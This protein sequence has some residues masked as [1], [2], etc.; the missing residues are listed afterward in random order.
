MKKLKHSKYKNTGILFEMLVH[1]LTSETMT[2]DKSISIDIIKKYFSKQSE[3]SKE[4]QLYNALVK[5]QF[6]S[7]SRALEYIRMIKESHSKLNK[8]VLRRQRYNLVKEIKE[9][10]QF[11]SLSKIR[12]KNYKTLA[13]AYMLFEY[14]ESD[15]P[16]TLMECKGVVLDHL[17]DAPQATTPVNSIMDSFSS[18]PK[19]VR[20]L[21]YEYVV[22]KFND[23]YSDL[24]PE[25]KSLLSKYI[26]HI[27]DSDSLKE[28]ISERVPEI[29]SRLAKQHKL[30]TDKSTAIKI[31]HLS[32]ML[33]NV[34]DVHIV[35]ESH[36]LTLLRYYNLLNELETVH[37][38]K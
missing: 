20:L 36:V 26:T 35:K 4:M 34:E 22:N 14:D 24:L 17:I 3:L 31:K 21:A 27:H 11:E 38:G 15:N 28:Y 30:V 8:S 12:I 25:Q 10:F 23:K 37:N 33:C 2:S 7:E 13:S 9:H 18:Q 5:E 29:K 16:K 32:E 1:Q 6:K 19:D